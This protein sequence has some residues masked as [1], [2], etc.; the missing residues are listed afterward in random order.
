MSKT[1]E[2][3][4]IFKSF[5]SGEKS[6]ETKKAKP[7]EISKEALDKVTKAQEEQ[8][9]KDL[10]E[11]KRTGKDPR[12]VKPAPKP[13]QEPIPPAMQGAE[14]DLFKTVTREPEPKAGMVK[15][16]SQENVAAKPVDIAP[17][18]MEVAAP[19][20]IPRPASTV[21]NESF[22]F[23]EAPSQRKTVIVVYGL[24]GHGKTYMAF[25]LVGTKAVLS[26]DRKSMR[27]KDFAFKNDKN[28]KV[29]DAVMHMDYSTP[30]IWLQS[31]DK[32]FRYC[33]A[34][35]R[36]TI[37]EFKPDWIMI[38]GTEIFQQICEMVMRYR[39]N[40]TAFQGFPNRNLWKERNMYV[41]QLHNLAI[42]IAKKG[43]IYT[44]YTAKEEIVKEGDLTL[45]IDVPKWIDVVLYETDVVVRILLEQD[46]SGTQKFYAIVE[47]SKVTDFPM[48][49]KVDVTGKGF[50][51][52]TGGKSK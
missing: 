32:T 16:E 43:V 19:P 28:I 41:R 7:A 2:L 26:F 39:N 40:I 25:T 8:T 1:D 23:A 4:D 42:E 38:D 52:I 47:T 33:E 22:D 14:D 36:G 29:W 51:A 31:A 15:A 46:K 5:A 18:F 17:D 20:I 24:K 3:D 30:D 50:A 13:K 11:K 34:L 48:T 27:V 21:T 35:L 37:A 6:P 9:A 12:V 10:E 45:K 49:G 44:T